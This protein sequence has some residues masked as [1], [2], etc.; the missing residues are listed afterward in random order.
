MET[1]RS[2][3]D[4]PCAQ[5]SG[6]PPRRGWRFA[7]PK[8][9]PGQHSF[10]AC[11][12]QEP[13]QVSWAKSLWSMEQC[14][15]GKSAKW[16]RNLGR[17]LGSKGWPGVGGPFQPVPGGRFGWLTPAGVA[18]AARRGIPPDAWL[19]TAAARSPPKSN[20]LENI[21]S[22]NPAQNRQPELRVLVRSMISPGMID[23]LPS[24]QTCDFPDPHFP[25]CP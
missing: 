22:P 7:L 21:R 13:Q 16:R 15:Q 9:N 18:A 19:Q 25:A 10:G 4:G 6:V 23:Y 1:N 11:P 14:S 8:E 17:S 20:L 24:F 5:D 2:S 3:G 12:Y